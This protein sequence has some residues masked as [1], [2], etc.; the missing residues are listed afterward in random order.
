[1]G[2][3]KE[4]RPFDFSYVLDTDKTRDELSE[5]EVQEALRWASLQEQMGI[6]GDILTSGFDRS[7]VP[8]KALGTPAGQDIAKGVDQLGENTIAGLL[9]IGSG[10]LNTG[11][12]I[13]AVPFAAADLGARKVGLD[14]PA[15]FVE[16]QFHKAGEAARTAPDVITKQVED[17]GIGDFLR[18]V[19]G[20]DRSPEAAQWAKE[21]KEPI[22]KS[23]SS[24]VNESRFLPNISS[25]PVFRLPKNSPSCAKGLLPSPNL[26]FA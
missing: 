7:H 22:E 16:E 25:N 18:D 12:G 19:F 21:V 1:M 5:E 4:I 15:D 20:A 26:F 24:F 14:K 23:F 3:L 17:A 11:A 8:T 2:K 9:N 13:G 10:L 6:A